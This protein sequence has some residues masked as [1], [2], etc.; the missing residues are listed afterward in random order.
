MP[1]EASSVPLPPA[2]AAGLSLPLARTRVY[3][4]VLSFG[5]FKP[6]PP[7]PQSALRRPRAPRAPPGTDSPA[8]LCPNSTG[9][10]VRRVLAAT[11]ESLRGRSPPR[12]HRTHHITLIR[13]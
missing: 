5:G 13:S 9:A 3:L 11:S 8:K 12:T 10:D 6:N 4:Y 7:R 1:Q 2:A